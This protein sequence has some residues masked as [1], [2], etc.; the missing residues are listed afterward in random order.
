MSKTTDKRKARADEREA[1]LEDVLSADPAAEV[2][3]A[4]TQAREALLV[5]QAVG[6]IRSILP[7]WPRRERRA[8][9]N[10]MRLGGPRYTKRTGL[11]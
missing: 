6:V 7:A 10:A 2:M 5:A 9:A 4:R 1:F 8:L 3:A 11:E